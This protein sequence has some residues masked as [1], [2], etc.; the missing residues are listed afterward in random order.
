[1]A[2]ATLTLDG[3]R[4]GRFSFSSAGIE[5]AV[6]CIQEALLEKGKTIIIDE[7]G[8]LELEHGQGL[9]AVLPKLSRAGNL[10]IVARKELVESI[11]ALVPRHSGR[12]FTLDAGNRLRISEEIAAFLLD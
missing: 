7:I 2:S 6:A 4:F 10:L 3:P 9:A 12:V 1:M 8:P 11:F 5:R